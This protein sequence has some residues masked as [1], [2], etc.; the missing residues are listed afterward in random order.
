MKQIQHEPSHFKLTLVVFL[1]GLLAGCATVYDPNVPRASGNILYIHSSKDIA[2]T[3]PTWISEADKLSELEKSARLKATQKCLGGPYKLI[4]LDSDP[5]HFGIFDGRASVISANISCTALET[6]NEAHANRDQHEAELVVAKNR[7]QELAEQLRIKQDQYEAELAAA[8]K[9]AQEL[10]EQLRIKQSGTSAAAQGDRIRL[11][12][13]GGTFKVPVRLNEQINLNFTID[14][15]ASDVTVPAD[16][17]MTL[18][19]TGT[20]KNS[21]F[22][23]EQAY[24]LADGSKIKSKTFILRT[25]QVGNRTLRNVQASLVDVNASLLLGQS[26]LKRFKSWSI[27]NTTHE[28]VLE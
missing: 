18:I 20:I 8:K 19:R 26:F 2:I 3:F 5:Y 1:G 10:A 11:I 6:P 25:I 4:D 15:G 27:D 22:R 28:L 14:S 7:E 17:V 12:E 21:D 13:S 16:V 24:V 9:H 23:G